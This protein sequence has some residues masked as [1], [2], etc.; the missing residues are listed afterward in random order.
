MCQI[1]YE[2]RFE[3]AGKRWYIFSEWSIQIRDTYC[4]SYCELGLGTFTNELS[5]LLGF[6]VTIY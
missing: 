5:C 3:Y 6:H 1:L 2:I 4:L